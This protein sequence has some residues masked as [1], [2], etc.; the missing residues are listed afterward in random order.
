MAENRRESTRKK[1][2]RRRTK[3]A[4]ETTEPKNTKKSESRKEAARTVDSRK[5]G[6]PRGA[7]ATDGKSGA[8]KSAPSR[9]GKKSRRR[10]SRESRVRG[11]YVGHARGFG[12]LVIEADPEGS[13]GDTPASD[14]FVPPGHEGQAIDGDLV[15]A[16]PGPEGT[17]RVVSVI[18]R[19]RT[20]VAGTF[21][22]GNEVAA[23]AHRISKHLELA[24]PGDARKGDKV[25]VRATT[26]GFRLAKVLGRAGAPEVEDAAILAEVEISP[27]FPRAAL[28]E[29]KKFAAPSAKDLE[30]RLDLRDTT[31]IVTIDPTTSRDFDD[32]I[33]LER[34][35]GGW[36]LGVHIADVS[37]YVRPE[38]ALDRE[39]RA[40]GTSVYLPNRVI[41]MLPERLSNDLCSLREGVDRLAMSVLLRYDDRGTL[42][43]TTFAESVIR[44]DRRFS[45]ERASRVMDGNRTRGAVE[46][47]LHDMADL[48]A[49][50]AERRPSFDIPRNEVELVYS[51]QGDVVDV[52]PIES[53]VAHG[54]IEEFMLAAN[55]EVARLFLARKIPALFRHHPEPADLEPVY[56]ALRT[57]G[58]AK[59]KRID[60]RRAMRR[61]VEAGF[62]P[63]VASA[64]L[65]CMP[66]AIYTTEHST[67]FS[68]GFEAYAHF[69]SPIRRYADLEVH[70]AL[71]ALL[72]KQRGP[73][74]VRPRKRFPEPVRDASLEEL[75]RHV[76]SR[77]E[78]ADR[79]ETRMRR[80]R[81][82]ELLLRLGAVPTEGQVTSIVERGLS[83]ELPEY[84]TWGFLAAEVLPG[85]PYALKDGALQSGGRTFRLGDSV[86]VVVHRIDP[87]AGQLDLALAPKRGRR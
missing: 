12:F 40:R 59:S 33:S 47:L 34:H 46:R 65:R 83:V 30:G 37:H 58:V 55:R 85:G 84:G 20:L 62:G 44:S 15:E 1:R 75:A 57:L 64:M 17:A 7:P 9:R 23:D 45:Y 43:S 82:L 60:L 50:L 76:S 73:L 78:S 29:A 22:G 38:T 18:E 6:A 49:K 79:A 68:L 51:G 86:D 87:G 71:R 77:A 3:A 36:R 48:A 41:P 42:L 52:R 28:A 31:T 63:S 81:V 27:K 21:L 5:S 24:K 25:L 72:R 67:H 80:R 61:A 66:R 2:S 16:V 32:A 39:A 14:R 35:K 70:R 13:A 8:P 26:S 74:E 53:D 19:G 54:V 56:D 11:R 4:R 69:T 10:G